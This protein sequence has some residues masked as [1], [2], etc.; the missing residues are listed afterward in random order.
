MKRAIVQPADLAG[1]ALDE[2]K[3]WL[4]IS[5]ANEDAMLEG[6]LRAA[7]DTCEGFTG[8]MPL[9][10]R[11]EEHL[12]AIAG[13]QALPVRPVVMI[14]Q[15]ESLSADGTRMPIAADRYMVDIDAGGCGKLRLTGSADGVQR[16]V[17][18]FTAGLAA[19]WLALPDALRQGVIR[20]AAHL[21]RSRD[22][23]DA[24]PIPTSV[25]AL[26]QP[27]RMLRLA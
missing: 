17:V 12:P 14:E 10:A 11:C 1:S 25:A 24:S 27:W 26:W 21:Y 5:R 22:R 19:D 3:L 20:L 9:Q 13:W 4:G 8:T 6:L 7:L 2:L 16:L 23:E 18:T 15:V